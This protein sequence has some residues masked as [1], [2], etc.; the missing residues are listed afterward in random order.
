MPLKKS[1]FKN[2]RRTFNLGLEMA[3]PTASLALVWPNFK[4]P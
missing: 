3:L 2:G 4:T 1:V